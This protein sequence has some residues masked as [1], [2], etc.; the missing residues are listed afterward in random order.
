MTPLFMRI[1]KQEF[2]SGLSLPYPGY[3]P[4]LGIEMVS[5]ALARGFF[6]NE[7]LHESQCRRVLY[8]WLKEEKKAN[9]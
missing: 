7:L 1:S 4:N 6:T 3:L 8:D 5:P 9:T 2:F